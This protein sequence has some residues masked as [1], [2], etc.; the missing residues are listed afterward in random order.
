M[1]A[2]E[3]R[4]KA[5]GLTLWLVETR[6][7]GA[8]LSRP[9]IVTGEVIFGACLDPLPPELLARCV[10]FADGGGGAAVGKEGA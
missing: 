9:V 7:D 10:P 2:H 1:S 6:D 3:G 8:V 5:E 4:M